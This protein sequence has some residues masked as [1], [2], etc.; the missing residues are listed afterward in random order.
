MEPEKTPPDPKNRAVTRS[1][2]LI[3]IIAPDYMLGFIRDPIGQVMLVLALILQ[4]FGF[5][6]IRKVVNIRV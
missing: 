4:L 3:A 2:F 6:W 1:L 5:L